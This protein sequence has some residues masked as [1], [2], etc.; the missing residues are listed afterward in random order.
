MS[1]TVSVELIGVK[2]LQ[3]KLLQVA[4]IGKAKK[5]MRDALRFAMKPLVKT[6]KRLAPKDKGDLANSIG[7]T[8]VIPKSGNVV[9]SAGIKMKTKRMVDEVVDIIEFSDGSTA[10]W[11]VKTNRAAGWRWHFAEYGTVNQAAHPFLR[12]AFD[13]HS[14]ELVERFRSWIGA[15]IV[16]LAA[17]QRS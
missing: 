10:D 13:Q 11:K 16:N 8:V 4:D 14:Q 2:E 6:A 12:P 17:K 5:T 7:L 1:K 9:M 3:A 15:A